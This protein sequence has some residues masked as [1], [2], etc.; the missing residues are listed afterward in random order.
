MVYPVPAS[1]HLNIRYQIPATVLPSGGAVW[2]LYDALGR[3]VAEVTLLGSSGVEQVSVEY[4]PAG[5]Y[6]YRVVFPITGQGVVS[7]KVVI[8]D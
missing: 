2:R 5:I 3:Q 8:S 7:G 1:T 4:L 6:Y